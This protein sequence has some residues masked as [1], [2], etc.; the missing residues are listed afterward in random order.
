MSIDQFF[1]FAVIIQGGTRRC[2]FVLVDKWSFDGL[3]LEVLLLN[4]LDLSLAQLLASRI[5]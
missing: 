3:P 4:A 5:G 2:T 1:P